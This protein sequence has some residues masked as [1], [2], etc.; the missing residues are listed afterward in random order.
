MKRGPA[1]EWIAGGQTGA[2]LAQERSKRLE[3]E[4]RFTFRVSPLELQALGRLI[5]DV[6]DAG[7]RPVLHTPPVTSI[8]REIVARSEGGPEFSAIRPALESMDPR[9]AGVEWYWCYE[10]VDYGGIDFADW[11]HLNRGGGRRYVEQLLAA[12]QSR[13]TAADWCTGARRR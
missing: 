1:R 3:R 10:A 12:V 13:S 6:T 9:V 8:Y 7:A 4:E 5:G 11:V 2:K